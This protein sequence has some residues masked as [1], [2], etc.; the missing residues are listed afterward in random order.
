MQQSIEAAELV[1][2]G[3]GQLLRVVCA[4]AFE[5]RGL[6][7]GLGMAGPDNFIIEAFQPLQ[8]SRQGD[9]RRAVGSKALRHG[10]AKAFRGAGDGNDAIFQKIGG[11]TEAAKGFDHE[12]F[13]G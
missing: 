5:I 3:M 2:D 6:Q 12:A 9:N 4:K 7:N 8:V 1:A 10:P 11:G 13:T